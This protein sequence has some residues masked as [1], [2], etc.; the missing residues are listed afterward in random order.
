MLKKLDILECLDVNENQ[1]P[2]VS[3]PPP[4]PVLLEVEALEIFF[5]FS[6]DRHSISLFLSDWHDKWIVFEPNWDVHT[7]LL[8]KHAHRADRLI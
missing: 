7:S 4:P 1:M 5:A 2:E 6:T 8:L 3:H